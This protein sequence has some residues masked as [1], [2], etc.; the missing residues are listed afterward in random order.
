MSSFD[1]SIFRA[2][3]IRGTVPDQMNEEVAY[4]AGQAYVQVMQAKTVAVGRDVRATGKSLQEALIRGITEA[5]ANV[6]N[7][8]VIST[9][10][11]YFAAQT[12]QCDGGMSVT[13]SHNPKEWNGIK[14]CGKGA[15]PM[16]V[17]A[18]LGKIYAQ[19]KT[20]QPVKA[21]QPGSV[22][23][24]DL[25]ERYTH[26][27]ERYVGQELF[28]M[29]AVLNPNYGANGKV[30]EAVI[31]SLP[32]ETTKL[33]WEENGEFPK[34]PPDPML[35]SNRQEISELV[36]STGADF[37]VAWDADADRCFFYDEKG[38][39]FHGYYITALLI[40]HFLK[41]QP[42]SAIV[43]D[44][45]LTWASLD[46]IKNNGGHI[47]PSRVGH[48][49]FKKHMRA[50]NAIFAGEISGHYYYREF[51]YCDNGM[52]TFLVMLG[53]FSQEKKSGRTVSQL[54]DHYMKHYPCSLQEL[55]YI[56][57]RAAE[58]IEDIKQKHADAKQDTLDGIS[59]EYP[60]WRCNIRPS[61]TQPVLRV[62]IEARTLAEL[63]M[64]QKELMTYLEEQGATL[65][66]DT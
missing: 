44:P 21:E 18:E 32:L 35:P 41:L 34:G 38:R 48:S 37:G 60:D 66:N 65:R 52:I 23:E 15:A 5:G 40:E 33:N 28:P 42:G 36:I 59:I 62:N 29:K 25:L 63:E 47:E 31:A 17:D 39:F 16:T 56:A 20:G 30:V 61:G 50:S 55:N 26:Y 7:V 58:I 10:M 27:L 51:A 53:I 49:F 46:A 43:T 4:A 6:I 11:L 8:G 2:Y 57:P 13:A 3:D 64:R 19:I 9:E 22:E 24:T 14:M 45:R 12:L 54:L 1:D